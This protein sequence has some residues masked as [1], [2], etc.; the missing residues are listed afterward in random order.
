[1][2]IYDAEVQHEAEMMLLGIIFLFPEQIDELKRLNLI[3]YQEFSDY[4]NSTSLGIHSR[5][6]Q[7]ITEVEHPDYI[8][9]YN[10]LVQKGKADNINFAYINHCV[11]LAMPFLP[12]ESKHYAKIIRQHHM[13]LNPQFYLNHPE[14]MRGTNR[15]K[16]DV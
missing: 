11:A 4:L 15:K 13:A 3:T 8:T 7:A 5:L 1:M 16:V 6:F 2:A 10:H 9:V 12:D 14:L